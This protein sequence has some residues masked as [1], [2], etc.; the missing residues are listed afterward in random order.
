MT[1][2]KNLFYMCIFAYKSKNRTVLH[3]TVCKKKVFFNNWLRICVTKYTKNK[4]RNINLSKVLKIVKYKF[5][6]EISQI[7]EETESDNKK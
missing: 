6:I 5:I 7:E 3:T 4:K 2:Y 1:V